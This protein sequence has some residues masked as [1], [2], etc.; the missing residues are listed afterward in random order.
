[1]REFLFVETQI[2]QYISYSIFQS[3]KFFFICFHVCLKISFFYFYICEGWLKRKTFIFH[4][5]SIVILYV[6]FFFNFGAY[7]LSFLF[8]FHIFLFFS[9]FTFYLYQLIPK[10]DKREGHSIRCFSIK[11]YTAIIFFLCVYFSFFLSCFLFISQCSFVN[12]TLNSGKRRE[13]CK[14]RVSNCCFSMKNYLFIFLLIFSCFCCICNALNC[15]NKEN[16]SF[17]NSLLLLLYL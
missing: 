16:K 14:E 8:W 5:I 6:F 1:V 12:F 2:F 7:V 13:K 4:Y 10:K 17:S 9:S 11:N 15:L 3:Y